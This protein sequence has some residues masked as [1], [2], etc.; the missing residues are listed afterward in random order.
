MSNHKKINQ[1]RTRIC[2]SIAR[3]NGQCWLATSLAICLLIFIFV[4]SIGLKAQEYRGLI[5]GQV[6]DPSGAVIHDARI[7]ARGAQQTY[8]AKTNASGDFSIPFVQ[9]GT[10][11]VSVEARGF[12]RAVEKNVIISVAQKA[13]LN[14]RLEVGAVTD[15]VEVVASA[16]AVNTA[17]ASGGT[18]IGQQETQNL[19]LNGRQVFMLMAL[20]PGVLFTTTSFG[21]TGNSGTRGWDQTNA[22]QINGVVNNQ[23]QFTLNGA[24][25]SQQTST[26]RGAWFVSPTVDAVQE[27]KIQTSNYD[28]SVGRSGGGTIN[29]VTKQGTNQFHGTLFD[30]WRNS[31]F[32]ANYFQLN[33]LGKPRG[34][35]NQHQFG[36]TVGGPI[37]KNKTFFFMAFEGH[38]EVLPVPVINTVPTGIVVNPDG[39]VNMNAYL[40]GSGINRNG[41]IY[42]PFQCATTNAD[43]T[44]NRRAAF[45]GN[46]IPANLVNPIGLKMLALYPQP[47]LPGFINNFEAS[48]GGIYKYNQPQIRVDHIFSDRT[49]LY[50]TFIWWSGSEFR[51]TSGF[52]DPRIQTGNINTTRS[53][54]SQSLSL[55]H[56]FSPTLVGDVRVSYG[57]AR[58]TS[59]NGGLAAGTG[60]LTPQDLGF[61]TY[62]IPSSTGL[63]LAPQIQINA[64]SV[65]NGD[66]VANLIGNSMFS[67]TGHPPFNASFEVSP[68]ISH[69]IGNHN[70]RYGGQYLKVL[71]IP[72]CGAGN[73]GNGP[74]GSFSFTNDFT[75]FN[76]NNASSDPT[77]VTGQTGSALA[78]M[79]LGIPNS[80]NIPFNL[81][82]YETYPY[83]ATFVQD[84]WKIH[85]RLTLNLGLRWDFEHSPHERH[86]RLNG[87]FCYVCVNPLTNLITFPAGNVLVPSTAGQT[88]TAGLTMPNPIMGGFTFLTNGPQSQGFLGNGHRAYDTQYNHIQPRIGASWAIDDKTVLR[89]GYGVNYGFAFELGGNTTFT[90]QTNYLASNAGSTTPSPGFTSNPYAQG[91]TVPVGAA[92][93]L[94]SSTGDGQSYDQRNRKITRVQHYSLGIQH[95]FPGGVVLD[96]SFVGTYSSNI[97]VGV[98]FDNLTPAQVS[99]CAALAAANAVSPTFNCASQVVNPFFQHM[100]HDQ[101]ASTLNNSK[102]VAAWVLMAAFPQFNQTLFSNTE[103]VGRTDYNSMQI[104]L[105]KR[106][107]GGPEWIKGLTLLSSFTW[108]K[109]MTNTTLN[110][111]NNGQCPGCVDIAGPGHDPL[112]P[113]IPKPYYQLDSNDRTLNFAFSGIWELPIGRNKPIAGNTSGWAGQLINNWSVDWIFQDASGTPIQPPNTF[114]YNCPQNNNSFIPAHRSFSE[115]I[116]NETP[117]CYTSL[118]NNTWIPRTIVTRQN[119]LRAPYKPQATFALQKQFDIR[120]ST[121]V[122]FR[123]EAFNA[124]NTP[125]F[126]GPSTSNP[127]QPITVNP[128]PG[129]QPGMPGYCTGY[130]CIGSNQQ[131]FPRQLQMSLKVLF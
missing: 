109:N 5:I 8:T 43:G 122:Q 33:Q 11:E 63:N 49:R 39:S 84:D 20:T 31:V 61:T 4:S 99:Q 46:V 65:T 18:V 66:Q 79:L 71:A 50:G 67:D 90:Q 32:D 44:C 95:E 100:P 41:G 114:T 27:F 123:A 37:R 121:K 13:N 128:I 30:Y 93:G 107:E 94:F 16:V 91:L 129:I 103:P 102:T 53:F 26:A 15:S 51:N 87:G 21:P 77:G 59:P 111:N 64:G 127:N 35:H 42:N 69:Q 6:K 96:T 68:T 10:Y 116:Y 14:F 29:I 131:N 113:F 19:P 104:T 80:G 101:Q 62:P 76:P 115:W 81:T 1:T 47:N 125:I 70:L 73:T 72:C 12:K 86:D 83:Y 74:N 23:N 85:P 56:T 110:N 17:D 92:D 97:R 119:T 22:Y 78:S 34:F 38:R 7:T 124:F 117:S 98:N 40:T 75:R 25:I 126:G 9:P 52:S 82:I 89:G 118:P 57:R 106:I 48:S 60:K 45:P 36:G 54:W 120:E 3:A 24:T 108:S 28:A 112:T 58:D 105:R 55:T 130:G 88:N 2:S